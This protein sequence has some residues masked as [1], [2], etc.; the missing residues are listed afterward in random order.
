MYL[1]C[2]LS[3]M[4]LS[5][6]LWVT[7]F[8]STQTRS[9]ARLLCVSWSLSYPITTRACFDSSWRTSVASVGCRR[10][11]TR[12]SLCLSSVKSFATFCSDQHGRTLC[13][14]FINSSSL[15]LTD[16]SCVLFVS[17]YEYIFFLR[18]LI[19]HPFKV[20]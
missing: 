10:G 14:H 1:F 2:K 3:P 5:F 7:S 17:I 19:E 13:K 18:E 12:R 4:S 6:N 9:P 15:F 20:P 8:Q 11:T 16:K